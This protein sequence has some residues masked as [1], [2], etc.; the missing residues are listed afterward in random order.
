M[1]Y[2]LE[3][4][5]SVFGE[6]VRGVLDFKWVHEVAMCVLHH[7]LIYDSGYLV[8][9]LN[10]ENHFTLGCHLRTAIIA[11]YANKW[12]FVGRLF[13]QRNK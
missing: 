1:F 8:R 6:P 12:L 2:I 3:I 13:H 7:R 9:F 11:F 4:V 10:A 5:V